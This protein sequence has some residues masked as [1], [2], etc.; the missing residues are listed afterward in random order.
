MKEYLTMREQDKYRIIKA[1]VNGQKTKT[2]AEIELNLTRRQINR[3]VQTYHEKGRKGFRHGNTGRKPATTL[4]PDLRRTIIRLYRTKYDGYNFKHFHE[5]LRET[6]GISISYTALR[7][8]MDRT[9]TLS[10]KSTRQTKRM[11]KDR[12]KQKAR[13]ANHMTRREEALLVEVSLVDPVKAHPTRPRAKAFGELLQMDASMHKW[14][15]E[16]HDYAHLHIAIDDCTRQIVGAWFDHQE[17]LN[18]YYAITEQCL[19]QYGLPYRLLTDNRTVFNYETKRGSRDNT[20]RANTQYGY[21]CQT[22]GIELSTTSIPQAKGRVERAF[23]TLQDRLVKALAEHHITSIP[24]A[25]QFLETYV[26]RFNRQFAFKPESYPSVF[27]ALPAGI[28][29]DRILARFEFRTIDNGHAIQYK[30]KKY[31]LI[32]ETGKVIYLNR[33][34]KV[35]VIE[36]RTGQ[37]FVSHQE[38]VYA[39]E[40]IPAVDAHSAAFEP[41][42]Q[43]TLR[44]V[45]IPPLSHPWKQRSYEQYLQRLERRQN[46]RRHPQ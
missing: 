13:S 44:S 40:E 23:G 37:L 18:G 30:N 38:Q 41:V 10:P 22:L 3:L 25:N 39:L 34:T 5:K 28:D 8:L 27:E 33:K 4:D 2:R 20:P 19:T 17:T 43:K 16:R 7:T 24:A 31:R 15:G 6:D 36:T 32:T 21:A 45:W 29:L 35:M 11:M 9:N 1:V 26:P 42:P 12:L 14:F 46:K